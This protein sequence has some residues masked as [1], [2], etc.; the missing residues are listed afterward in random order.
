MEGRKTRRK[1]VAAPARPKTKKAAQRLS[2]RAACIR[3]A[4]ATS[5]VPRTAMLDAPTPNYAILTPQ[6]SGKFAALVAKIRAL[7]EEDV[8]R[9]GTKFK[10]FIFTDIRESA[11]GAKALASYMIAHGFAFQMRNVPKTMKRKGRTLQT[12][13]GELKF[14]PI[15]GIPGGSNTFAVLQSQPLWKNPT[16]VATKKEILRVYNSRP[17]NIHGEQL[18]ILLLDSKFKEGIDL[19]DVKYVHLLEPPIAESDMKQA[20]GR[21]TRFC[22]Q[23]GLHFVPGRGWRLEVFVYNTIVP[24]RPPF[25][26]TPAQKV[27]AHKLMLEHAGIDLGLLKLTSELTALAIQ[28]AVDYDLNLKMN[29]FTLG[30]VGT[31]SAG[32]ERIADTELTH[33]FAR[34]SRKFPFTRTQMAAAANKLRLRI[35]PRARRA[36][37][38]EQLGVNTEYY[39]AMFGGDSVRIRDSDSSR[40]S[41]SSDRNNVSAA[42]DELADAAKL[43]FSQ[44]QRSIRTIYAKYAW[45]S[46][47]VE[48]GCAAAAKQSYGQPVTFT[49]TQDFVRHYLTPA[50][51]FKGLLAWHSVG[52]GKT[53]MAVAAAS[54]EFEQAGYTILWVTRNA[55]M[56]DVYK[57]TFGAVCSIPLIAAVRSGRTIPASLS[58]AKRQLSRV[59]LAPISYRTFQNALLK[60]NKLGRMLHAKHGADPLHR[61]FLIMDEVHKLL[62]GDL[63]AAEAADFGVIQSFIHKSYAASGDDSVR[64]LLMTATPISD[65]PK[66]LFA[67]LNTLIARPADRL[68]AFDEFRARYTG[69]EGDI[70]ADGRAYFQARAKGLISYL[71]REYDPTTFAQ[72]AFHTINVPVG[73]SAAPDAAEL[74][75]LYL[76][77]AARPDLDVDDA[78][79]A[80]AAAC[81]MDALDAEIDAVAADAALKAKEKKARMAALKRTRRACLAAARKTK[82]ARDAATKTLL[83]DAR[84][85]Y[86][87]KQK[88]YAG[89][90]KNSQIFALAKCFKK[91]VA[92]FAKQR[93]FIAALRER[94]GAPRA[95]SDDD[96]DASTVGATIAS[97]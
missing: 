61:T 76:E 87:I 59:W 27:E 91:S 30:A 34:P 4:A 88:Q 35:P 92:P 95:A 80:D 21:A 90:G 1:A 14:M 5:R 46:P 54:T 17:E 79:A 16:Q 62:D 33:C 81:D 31:Q 45:E 70:S 94:L 48:N 10:H 19:F 20:V 42:S 22:G 74:A 65:S 64:P 2:A 25:V 47:V 15:V 37:F 40:D 78:A 11:Y 66:D 57:N 50:S 36:W 75:D 12:K 41:G 44:F 53:C 72:P 39:D 9:H 32:G 67:I 55:L 49:Q 38:C 83:R 69:A 96:D 8:A 51:P 89:V 7:D 68:M 18:R 60:K 29:K 84:A 28:T 97:E 6:M 43:S 24:G 56:A 63:G 85:F 58:R 71:N 13:K 26:T 77:S 73:E 82:K 3:K 86:T 93:E 52:T 23:R